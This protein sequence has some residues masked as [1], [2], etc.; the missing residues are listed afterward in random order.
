MKRF[1]W[2]MTPLVALAF[3]MP[4]L[5][6]DHASEKCPMSTQDCLNMM[7]E[8]FQNKGWLGVELDMNDAG[9]LVVTKVVEDS[10][11][12][13]AGLAEGDVLFAVNGI[14]YGDENEEAVKAEWKKAQPGAEFTFTILKAGSDQTDVVVELGQMPEDVMYAYI[15]KH[16]VDDHTTVTQA[17]EE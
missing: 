17:E 12:E 4:A 3:A 5:A 13:S 9:Q 14:A 15:G 6:G 16:L 10:P 1:L 8:R 2:L 7:A 11:A